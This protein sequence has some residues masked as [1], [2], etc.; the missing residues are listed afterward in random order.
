MP[1]RK[2]GLEVKYMA[3]RVDGTVRDFNLR[4]DAAAWLMDAFDASQVTA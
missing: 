1:F 4:F 2:A 3:T